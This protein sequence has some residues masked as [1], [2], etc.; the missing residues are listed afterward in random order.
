MALNEAEDSLL[1][2][3][4][5]DYDKYAERAEVQL[6]GR[7]IAGGSEEAARRQAVEPV[8]S[9]YVRWN[10]LLPGRLALTAM[11]CILI[12]EILVGVAMGVRKL[13][14]VMVTWLMHV[15]LAVNVLLLVTLAAVVVVKK[16]DIR[17]GAAWTFVQRHGG[18]SGGDSEG[19]SYA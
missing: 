5:F 4:R 15:L 13:R 8:A 11:A 1:K 7:S 10:V 12:Y 3:N 9:S 2:Y 6:Q 16:Y 19:G 17:L 14:Y 18:S